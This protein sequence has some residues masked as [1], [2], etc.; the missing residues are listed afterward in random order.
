MQTSLLG[1]TCLGVPRCTY[2]LVQELAVKV[3]AG[4]LFD[5]A[6]AHNDA[7]FHRHNVLVGGE[8]LPKPD[9]GKPTS[10]HLAPHGL[11]RH[12]VK[13][14]GAELEEEARILPPLQTLPGRHP[15]APDEAF[16]ENISRMFY[17]PREA[18]VLDSNIAAK[19]PLECQLQNSDLLFHLLHGTFCKSICTRV[20]GRAAL[21]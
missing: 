15:V 11:M 3:L 17:Q 5:R 9:S 21:D 18:R 12:S 7:V 14:L 6:G 20:S 19:I 16:G 1:S 4:E 8:T 2:D 10:L 13:H